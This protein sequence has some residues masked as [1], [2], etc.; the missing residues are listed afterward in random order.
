[1]IDEAT[2]DELDRY[3]HSV[4]NSEEKS[5]FESR[6]NASA[7]LRAEYAWL[8]TMLGGMKQQGRSVVKQTVA[9]T[10]AA[11]SSGDVAKYKP[12]L[13]GKFFSW[14][15]LWV[16]ASAILAVAIAIYWYADRES[17]SEDHN[18]IRDVLPQEAI[19][20]PDSSNGALLF[21]VD[22]V[23]NTIAT[24]TA[25]V[26][27]DNYENTGNVK[28]ES[29]AIF[30]TQSKDSTRLSG[31]KDENIQT[32]GD[33]RKSKK[34]TGVIP[35]Y[36]RQPPFTYILEDETLT[37]NSPW[38]SIKGFKFDD[39]GDTVYMTN[40]DGEKYILLRNQGVNLLTPMKGAQK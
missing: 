6:M 3:F 38:R 31:S 12:S 15:Y 7:D 37:L 17:R 18:E 1:M 20:P 23:K 26:Y 4:M 10:I 28:P 40:L 22:T 36:T 32:S 5:A 8:N 19:S 21:P 2:Y 25:Y 13:N 34:L 30:L 33:R 9:S 24:E 14:K 29:H 27:F 11:V 35:G 16:V 39:F